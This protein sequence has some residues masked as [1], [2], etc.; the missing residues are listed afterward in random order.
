M[1]GIILAGGNGTRLHP[2]T[3]AISKHL[4]PIYD[5]PMIYYPLS[6]LMLSGIRDILIISTA[7]HLEL[8]KLLL[9]DGS[10]LGI[11]ISY[12]IQEKPEGIG[13]AFVLGE[14]FI[15][16]DDVCLVLGDN[17]FYGHGLI[18]TFRDTI[19]NLD[20]ATIFGYYV[21]DPT[22]FG[23]VEF[24]SDN[25]AI[26]IEE[27]PKKPKSNF[28]VPGIYFY[29][30]SVIEVAKSIK[31]SDRNEYEIS[32]INAAY[33]EKNSLSVVKLG[34]GVAW[35]DTGTY[36]GLLEAS[37]YVEAIQTRQGLYIAS[38]EE[39]AFT[40]KY[41]DREQFKKLIKSYKDNDYAKYLKR[42]LAE[43][44]LIEEKR[45]KANE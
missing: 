21:S 39:I 8:Y 29:D 20:K 33:L 17:I 5:K 41:I 34:R 28:A 13:Q 24:D 30:N 26:S 4:I 3:K 16:N 14:E 18:R 36:K 15:G 6:V 7:E 25:K 35:L 40:E 9:E 11:N 38:L 43:R 45:G 31:K 42:I 37:N 10:Q 27:K 23:V 1:K 32:A 19:A 2:M 22:A 12:K 44:D